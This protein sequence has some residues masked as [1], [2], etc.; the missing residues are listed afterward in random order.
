MAQIGELF[1]DNEDEL[2]AVAILRWALEGGVSSQQLQEQAGALFW[3]SMEQLAAD[4][5]TA[6]LHQ[7]GLQQQGQQGAAAAAAAAGVGQSASEEAGLLAR[8]NLDCVQVGGL[9]KVWGLPVV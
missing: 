4:A 1:I 7:G 6:G 5:E 3:A 9:C 2:V 8:C